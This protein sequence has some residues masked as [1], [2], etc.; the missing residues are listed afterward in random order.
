MHQKL[1]VH[2]F[3]CFTILTAMCCSD[4]IIDTDDLALFTVH[5]YV[6][7]LCFCQPPPVAVLRVHQAF[8]C[9]I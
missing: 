6:V 2:Q 8:Y 4:D 9:G 7:A 3:N 1:G 5:V